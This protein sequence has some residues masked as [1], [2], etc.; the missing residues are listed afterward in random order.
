MLAIT[1]ARFF[2]ST[3]P[4]APG[5]LLSVYPVRSPIKRSLVEVAGLGSIPAG[6]GHLFNRNRSLIAHNLSLL[7][8]H[9]PGLIEMLLKMTFY[10]KSFIHSSIR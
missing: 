10:P 9:P 4:K 3:E 6:F 1:E 8:S 2:N 5:N 7:P